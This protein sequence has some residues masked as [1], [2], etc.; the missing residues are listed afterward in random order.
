MEQEENIE[1]IEEKD[2]Q[3]EISGGEDNGVVA[4]NEQNVTNE[5]TSEET[6]KKDQNAMDTNKGV[7]NIENAST[8][9]KEKKIKIVDGKFLK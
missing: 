2:K 8:E 6:E 5:E 9:R 7:E 4:N 3:M 1:K